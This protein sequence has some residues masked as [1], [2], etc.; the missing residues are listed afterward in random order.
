MQYP[1]QHAAEGMLTVE[2][3]QQLQELQAAT[4]TFTATGR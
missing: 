3:P 1:L 4:A 2:P